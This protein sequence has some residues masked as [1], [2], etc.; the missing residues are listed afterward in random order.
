MRSSIAIGAMLLLVSLYPA[1]AQNGTAGKQPS[2]SPKSTQPLGAGE[3]I[4]PHQQ[5]RAADFPATTTS[6]QSAEDRAL[7]RKLKGICRGC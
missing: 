1:T 4:P 2:A 5:P 3:R 7:D 6:D